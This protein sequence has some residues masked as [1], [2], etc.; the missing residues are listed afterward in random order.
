MSISTSLIVILY[1]MVT[2]SQSYAIEGAWRL[3]DI[4]DSHLS[5]NVSVNITIKDF[6]YRNQTVRWSLSAMGCQN[7]KIMMDIQGKNIFIDA[8]TL[9]VDSSNV[10]NCPPE[11]VVPDKRF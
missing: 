1:S 9:Y 2:I 8:N 10:K 3:T 7:L 5:S 6:V 4:Q 11:N